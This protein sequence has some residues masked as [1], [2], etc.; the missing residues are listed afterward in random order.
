MCNGDSQH[1][2][3]QEN[4]QSQPIF[5]MTLQQ[6]SPAISGVFT[7]PQTVS[8]SKHTNVT[9]VQIFTED[10][11]KSPPINAI[12]K[13]AE[14]KANSIV[15]DKMQLGWNSM[16]L[17]EKQDTNLFVL[18]WV[19]FKGKDLSELKGKSITQVSTRWVQSCTVVIVSDK[20]SRKF[21]FMHLDASDLDRVSK[22][23][24]SIALPTAGSLYI[25]RIS[26]NDNDE[27]DTS[28]KAEATFEKLIREKASP[29]S[30]VKTSR[31]DTSNFGAI[32]H[33]HIVLS[34][35]LVVSGDFKKSSMKGVIPQGGF[36]LTW[37]PSTNDTE[38]QPLE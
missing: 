37:P 20:E 36:L 15:D 31:G 22:A 5:N 8:S 24:S 28:S 33:D 17:L 38:I 10:K 4:K 12:K 35:D 27:S 29:A 2:P 16:A 1:L 25:S 32:S 3:K 6:E 14:A 9:T 13:E 7:Q 11:Y 18:N 23:I 26:G 30:F 21:L 19:D 34:S